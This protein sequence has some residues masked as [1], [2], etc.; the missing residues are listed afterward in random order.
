[1]YAILDFVGD[2]YFPIIDKITEELEVI[3]GDISST[4]PARER[5]ERLYRLRSG[6]LHMRCRR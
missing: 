3:E 6:L 5:I 2:N 4:P 1:M